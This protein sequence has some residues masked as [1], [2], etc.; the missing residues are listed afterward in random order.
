[1]AKKTP[2][3]EDKTSKKAKIVQ[4]NA[5]IPDNTDAPV[6]IAGLSSE[7]RTKIIT[8]ATNEI[9]FARRYKQ[10]KIRNWQKNEQM[11]YGKKVSTIES[12]A[13]VDLSRMQEHVHTILSKIDDPLVFNF[14]KKKDSQLKRAQRLNAIRSWDAQRDNW[15]IKDIVGKKQCIIYG[16]AAYVYYAD[17]FNGYMPH[18]ENIDIYDLLVDPSGGGIDVELMMYWGRYGVVKTRT[19]LETMLAAETDPL[20]R[21]DIQALLDGSGNATDVTQ[22]E[23]NKNVR[24]YGNNVIGQ[25]QVQTDEKYKFWQWFTTFKGKRYVLTINSLAGRATEIKLLTDKFESNLWPLLTYAAFMDLTEFWTPSYCDYVREMFMTQ[26]T[27]INQMLD[28][29]EAINKP[30]KV[31]N[32]SA[33]ENLAELKYRRDG[34]IK[35]RGNF[36]ASKAV[37]IIETPSINTPIEV[38]NTIEA[39]LE[40]A[41]GV[42]ES[43]KGQEDT[44]GKVAI[45]QGNQEAVQGRYGLFNKSYSFMYNRFAL[46]YQWGVKENLIVKTAIEIYGPDG[47]DT[48]VIQRNDIFKKDETFLVKVESSNAARN[49]QVDKQNMKIDFLDGWM[50]DQVQNPGIKVMNE[51]KAFEIGAKI[52]GFHEDEIKE[53]LDIADYEDEELMSQAAEDIED[54]LAGKKLKPNQ[55]A[56]NAYKQK[57]VDYMRAYQRNLTPPQYRALALYVISLTETIAK[58]MQS[59]L[60]NFKTNMMRTQSNAIANAPVVP[61]SLP[62]AGGAPGGGGGA[63]IGPLNGGGS[64]GLQNIPVQ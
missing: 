40:K 33:I 58:N 11:Y 4:N 41:S 45:Y 52:A 12:R 56:N 29:A 24:M 5:D 54:I 16:R 42:T 13:N 3:F 7:D 57:I 31:V 2:V 62:A 15:D 26:D 49:A 47:V 21:A 1:M 35:T 30:Q 51:Q 6:I 19:D 9:I 64:G 44:R 27:S 39:I 59:D 43:D 32:V 28:N 34:L 22:E 17:S 46:L 50:E 60:T 53:L 37:Q 14:K 38:F 18:F 61:Q 55:A 8:Q 48:Q 36:D 10:G 25:K 20:V 63:P 23:T